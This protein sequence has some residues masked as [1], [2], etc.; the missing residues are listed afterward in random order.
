MWV[1]VYSKRNCRVLQPNMVL[2][3]I[4]YEMLP[5]CE[6]EARTSK[7]FAQRAIKT[8]FTSKRNVWYTSRRSRSIRCGH[9]AAAVAVLLPTKKSPPRLTMW[10]AKYKT[11]H[12]RR[13]LWP[14]ASQTVLHKTVTWPKQATVYDLWPGL[15]PPPRPQEVTTFRFLTCSELV[16]RYQC[17]H[18]VV[19]EEPGG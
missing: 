19:I 4:H 17:G 1:A 18:L 3:K 9:L 12:G 7:Q 5:V 10:H 6:I 8:R 15:P 13:V 14:Q 2:N 16:P 11:E